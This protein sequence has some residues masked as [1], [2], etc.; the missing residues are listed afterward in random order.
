ML[1]S[2]LR[3]LIAFSNCLNSG[4]L[5]V[6][7]TEFSQLFS[8]FCLFSC[9]STSVS[10]EWSNGSCSGVQDHVFLNG[11]F[12]FE[13]ELDSKSSSSFSKSVGKSLSSSPS[14][15]S[16]MMSS[17]EIYIFYLFTIFKKHLFTFFKKI[18]HT[19]STFF[20]SK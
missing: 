14:S 1:G 13:F 18:L 19:K 20:S 9:W 7:L 5:F 16:A 10:G 8:D 3:L 4:F 6:D 2:I 15:S 17:S 12:E 11:I